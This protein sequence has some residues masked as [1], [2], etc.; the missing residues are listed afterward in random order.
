METVM[1]FA[2][3]MEFSG[4]NRVMRRPRLE[5]LTR[6]GRLYFPKIGTPRPVSE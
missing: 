6:A 4:A 1:R 3:T 2:G 5:Q